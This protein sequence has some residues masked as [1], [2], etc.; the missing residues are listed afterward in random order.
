MQGEIWK[1]IK[2]YDGKYYVSNYGRIKSTY[3]ASEKFLSPRD[4]GKGYMQVALFKDHKAKNF[5]VH[6]IVAEHFVENPN[7]FEFVNHKDENK[8]NNV[9]SNLEWCNASYNNAYGTR[10][11]K[12]RK[13]VQQSLNGVVI[14]TYNS[15]TEAGEAIGQNSGSISR[16]CHGVYKTCGGYE[17][18]LV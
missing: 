18:A 16:C 6:R 12:V 15:M 14:A 9:Y 3:H 11:Q 17:W 5:F 7:G 8:G 2:G 1:P 10:M 13:K 4:A